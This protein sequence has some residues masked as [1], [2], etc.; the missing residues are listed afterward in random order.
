MKKV[1]IIGAG[2]SGLTAGIYLQKAGITTEIYEKNQ[3]PGGQCTGWKREGYFIDNCIHW[4]TGTKEGSGL[5]ELWKEV[6]ALGQDVEL[7]HKEKFYTSELNGETITFW[8]DKERTRQE[9]LSL[10]PEDQDEICPWRIWV[11][12]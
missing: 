4:L 6:G 5:N 2:I 1:V 7:Y 12:S 3:V 9:L 10:S 11:R 8:R